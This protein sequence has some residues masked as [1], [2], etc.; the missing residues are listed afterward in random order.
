MVFSPQ[1]TPTPETEDS[2]I[3][4]SRIC[5]PVPGIIPWS[6]GMAGGRRGTLRLAT[7]P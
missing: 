5:L 1:E 7:F 6:G 3:A 2:S 4:N